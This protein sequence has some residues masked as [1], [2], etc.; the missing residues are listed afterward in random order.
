MIEVVL[1]GELREIDE[2]VYASKSG[3]PYKKMILSAGFDDF[4]ALVPP[5]FAP[6]EGVFYGTLLND[7]DAIWINEKLG[8]GK[9]N[10]VFGIV[11]VDTVSK[12]GAYSGKILLLNLESDEEG[13]FFIK[14]KILKKGVVK[15]EKWEKIF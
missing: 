10:L 11:K 5:Y 13:Y 8:K 3:K 9:A 14:G 6:G 12:E 7:G 2:T 1:S 4:V 15:A